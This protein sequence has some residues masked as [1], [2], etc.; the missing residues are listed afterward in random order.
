MFEKKSIWANF[1][2]VTVLALPA[3]PPPQYIWLPGTP[4]Q[5][6]PCIGWREKAW[7]CF[8]GS[9]GGPLKDWHPAAD[10]CHPGCRWYWCFS[11][12]PVAGAWCY[13]LGLWGR[14]MLLV[15]NCPCFYFE[16][17]V[18]R[19]TCFWFQVSFMASVFPLG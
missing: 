2:P 14:L 13:L 8:Q 7:V 17:L 1:Q 4:D 19:N 5:I 9:L 12:E 15:V 18:L 3:S 6:R 11:H 16:I 10:T